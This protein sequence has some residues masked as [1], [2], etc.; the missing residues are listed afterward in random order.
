MWLE[1]TAKQDDGEKP[2]TKHGGHSMMLGHAKRIVVPGRQIRLEI[3]LNCL[4]SSSFSL[5]RQP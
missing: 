4:A 1:F 5:Q 3:V 2:A